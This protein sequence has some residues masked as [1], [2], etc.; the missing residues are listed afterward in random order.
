MTVYH[1]STDIIKKP[2]VLHSKKEMNNSL[3]LYVPA[4]KEKI[5]SQSFQ[6]KPKPLTFI[7]KSLHYYYINSTKSSHCQLPKKEDIPYLW[8]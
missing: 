8:P 1:V 7:P 3:I 4:I 5:Y 2:D 6:T